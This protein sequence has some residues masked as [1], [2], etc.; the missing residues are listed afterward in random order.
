MSDISKSDSIG[1][2]VEAL[3]KAQLSFGPVKKS[4]ENA[5]FEDASKGKKS[6]YADLAEVIKAT[7]RPL[8]E[9]GLVVIQLPLVDHE[10]KCAGVKT[11]LVHS[12]GEWISNEVL[13]PAT[14][15]RKSYEVVPPAYVDKFDAQT[16]GIAIT[17]SRRYSYQSIVGVAAEVDDDANAISI[18]EGSKEAAQ[19]V[20]Q[21]KIAAASERK[22]KTA[23]KAPEAPKATSTTSEETTEIVSGPLG[24]VTS[25]DAKGNMKRTSAGSPYI[26]LFVEGQNIPMYDNFKRPIDTKNGPHSI[27]DILANAEPDTFVKL[28]VSTKIVEGAKKKKVIDV[29]SIG[30]LEWDESGMPVR[31][32]NDL[33]AGPYKPTDSD[34]P[35]EM[36]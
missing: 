16:S 33:P 7:Q 26:T 32:I 3:A 21:E 30:A 28:V 36:Q 1:N 24:A 23:P 9:N 15:R 34:L 6:F 18:P 4:V 35:K 25:K 10:S 13:L 20:A 8:A 5:A 14:S 27:F 31:N 19:A 2:L 12:S 29:V 22:A 11:L 17:Y